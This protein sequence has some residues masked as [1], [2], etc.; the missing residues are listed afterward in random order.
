[1]HYCSHTSTAKSLLV[2]RS[3]QQ[4]FSKTRSLFSSSLFFAL[5]T[6]YLCRE[7]DS[8]GYMTFAL[9][10]IQRLD[11]YEADRDLNRLD[12]HVIRNQTGRIHVNL[13]KPK[14]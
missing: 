2:V 13:L 14:I 6:H 8:K 11:P 12:G 1:M 7:R 3:G 10:A 9:S 5:T 4:N